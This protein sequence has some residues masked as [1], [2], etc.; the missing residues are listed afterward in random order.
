MLL[1]AGKDVNVYKLHLI[2]AASASNAS[3]KGMD[4]NKILETAGWHRSRTFAKFYMRDVKGRAKESI[5]WTILDGVEK[6]VH[7]MVRT[8]INLRSYITTKSFHE[9][10]IVNLL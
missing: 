10:V 6:P 4:Q 2:W 1:S 9:H 3:K 5:P 8:I 7:K